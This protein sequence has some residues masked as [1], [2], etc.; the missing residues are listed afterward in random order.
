MAGLLRLAPGVFTFLRR[1]RP[2]LRLGSF[3]LVTRYDDVVEVFSNDPVFE[4]PYAANLKVITGGEPFFLGMGEG[5][6][7]RAQL[8]AMRSVVRADDLATLGD[9]AEALARAR[10]EESDG[11]IEVLQFIRE[12]AFALVGDYFGV[13][14]G[15]D[16]T[17]AF[18]GSRLFEF[19]FTGSLRDRAWLAEA[20]GI[21]HRL[22]EH[23][24][25]AIAARKAGGGGGRDDV[26]QRCIALQGQGRAGYGDVEIRTALLCMIVGGPPQ[27]PMVVPQALDQLL[28]RPDRLAAARQ[29]TETGDRDMLRGIVMEAMRFD[30]LAPGFRRTAV[31]DHVLARGTPRARA[32]K[33]G[34][35]IFAATAS[36]M[37]DPR[38]I[39]GP[40]RFDPDRQPHEYL[41]FGHGLHECFGRHINHATLHRMLMPLLEK[42]GLR[43]AGRLIKRG[44]F[45]HQLDV[46]F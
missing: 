2:I 15:E 20:D 38:R 29:A 44:P 17:L 9:R 45:A 25:R 19:Q 12:I 14:E 41:H 27:P 13:P 46:A 4:A 18:A 33:A 23:I 36:A 43:R 28:R 21:A 34:A 35:T 6:E 11:R 40:K 31:V 5:A 16:E 8:D 37:M 30:P 3:C 24:D 39:A 32:V 42:P 10:V 22:R 26:L 1:H 7:Y